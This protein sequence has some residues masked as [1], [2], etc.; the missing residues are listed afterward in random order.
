MIN[1]A[2]FF[3]LH[4]LCETNSVFIPE[5]FDWAKPLASLVSSVNLDIPIIKKKSK[6]HMIHLRRNPIVVHFADGSKIFLSNDE[7]RRI[8]KIEV[9]DMVDY[10]MFDRGHGQPMI[11]KSI[12]VIS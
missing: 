1:F 4:E 5:G 2:T 12:R 7:Y 8:P 10:S 9:G 6:I 11:V 3:N